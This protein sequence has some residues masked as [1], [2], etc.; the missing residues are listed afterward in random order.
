MTLTAVE[1]E[2]RGEVGWIKIKPVQDMIEASIGEPDYIEVHIGIAMALEQFRNDDI[3]RAIVITGAQDGEFHVAPR[4]SHYDDKDCAARLDR[5]SRLKKLPAK[6]NRGVA[7]ALEA[8]TLCEIPVICRLNGDA[9]GF[10][11]S[12]MYGCDIIVAREDAVISDVHLGQGDVIDHQGERRGFPWGVTP[13]DGV[14]AFLPFFMPPTKMKEYLFLSRAFT[15]TDLA[16][17]NI[18]NYAIP[19]AEL[20][21]KIDGLLEELLARP[22]FALARTKRACNKHLVNQMNLATDYAHEAEL[23][24]FLDHGRLGNMDR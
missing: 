7:R 4:I 9:I 6:P 1:T 15:A 11:Q 23:G 20:D 3:T 16:A 8:L 18:I 10:G 2:Q 24:D 17:M 21:E 14:L 22:A 19:L 12:V 5:T 13:G